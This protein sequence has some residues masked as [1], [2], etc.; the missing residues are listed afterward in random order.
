MVISHATVGDHPA[1]KLRGPSFRKSSDGPESDLVADFLDTLPTRSQGLQLTAFQEPRLG[2]WFPDLVIVLWK[3]RITRHWPSARRSLHG[4][5]FRTLQCLRGLGQAGTSTLSRFADYDILSSLDRL[6]QADLIFQA[7]HTWR[8]RSIRDS[9]AVSRLVA[10]E[11]KVTN[12]R[13]GIRQAARN[14]WFAS[15][16]YLLLDSV[17]NSTDVAS[18]A[19]SHDVGLLTL[20]DHLSEPLATV[21]KRDLPRSYV[22]WL[23]NDWAW[24]T[25]T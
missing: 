17:P 21:S 19:E 9:F 10:I 22:S 6:L 11:A 1:L 20:K 25:S 18:T 12:W 3:S 5:D 8:P 23:F 24:W 7:S 15:E 14:R 4:N 2:T 13:Q 16:S